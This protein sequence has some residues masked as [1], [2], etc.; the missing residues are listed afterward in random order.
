MKSNKDVKETAGI[1]NSANSNQPGVQRVPSVQN[2]NGQRPEEQKPQN[3]KPKAKKKSGFKKFMLTIFV[4]LILLGI[5]SGLGYFYI[6]DL[7]GE[8]NHVEIP[9]GDSDLGIG[10]RN[11]KYDDSKVNLDGIILDKYT[12]RNASL[13]FYHEN[14]RGV[15][16][17]A[18][19]GIDAREGSNGRSDAII[20][21]TIDN[22]NRNIKL[23]SIIRDSY[24]KIEGRGM[25][26]INHAYIF[27]GPEL[28]IKTLNQ[29][30]N[31]DIR[32]FI[33][34]N[35]SSMPKVIDSIG[36]IYLEITD[37][38]AAIITGIDTAGRHLLDGKQALEFSRIRKIDSDLER[39]RR[40][41]DV[42]ESLIRKVLDEPVLEYPQI[43]K[44]IFPLIR[45]NINKNTMIFTG[46]NII[47]RNIRTIEQK[48]FPENGY[49]RGQT[50][51]GVYYYVFDRIAAVNEMG[52]FIYLNE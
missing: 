27:G 32:H 48:R 1:K 50:I 17:I 4:L 13:P 21:L 25:D 52:G 45:T 43:S 9:S 15:T 6:Y 39:S 41:R 36:G 42:I 5:T 3:L 14:T 31:L 35:F 16:N 40:Q 51:N 12:D 34:V 22:R 18:I 30:F 46:A 8:M 23:S 28:A 24:V 38:E 26:K 49:S 2:T 20:I 44:E 47:L 29:N 11:F 37:S 33:T 19:F 7:L 10:D